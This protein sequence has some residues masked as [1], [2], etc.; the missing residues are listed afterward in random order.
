MGSGRTPP[1]GAGRKGRFGTHEKWAFRAEGGEEP[2]GA[3]AGQAGAGLRGR[4]WPLFGVGELSMSS[5]KDEVVARIRGRLQGTVR[6]MAGGGPMQ[7]AGEES[8]RPSLWDRVKEGLVRTAVDYVPK[9]LVPS[10]AGKIFVE[11]VQGQKAPITEKDFAPEE[12]ATMQ[13]LVRFKRQKALVDPRQDANS[14]QLADY[15]EYVQTL[16]REQQASFYSAG[17]APATPLANVRKTLGRFQFDTKGAA[18]QIRDEYDF[19]NDWSGTS[20]FDIIRKIGYERLPEGKGRPVRVLLPA[21]QPEPG[22]Q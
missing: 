12:L 7:L 8:L 3:E 2:A 11:S 6:R 18:P 10:T 17:L 16:P 21:T 9:T 15:D 4:V 20:V 13:E 14:I 5:E 22:Q 1:L 19:N